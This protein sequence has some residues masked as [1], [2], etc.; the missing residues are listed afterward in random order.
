MEQAARE[1]VEILSGYLAQ[2]LR[3]A[4]ILRSA[5]E[6]FRR[7]RDDARLRRAVYRYARGRI[8]CHCQHPH[9]A[10]LLAGSRRLVIA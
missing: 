7:Q 2:K 4:D 6:L 5:L 3:L 9:D 8:A 1:Q 10:R